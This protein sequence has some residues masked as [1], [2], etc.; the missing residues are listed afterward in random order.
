MDTLVLPAIQAIPVFCQSKTVT[1]QVGNSDDKLTQKL[2]HNFCE[3]MHTLVVD[4]TVEIHFSGSSNPTAPWQNA[5]W[6]AEIQNIDIEPFMQRVTS[7]RRRYNQASVAL[8]F[9][10]TKFI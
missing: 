10:E 1:V 7:L 3:E 8:T 9:G 6:V 4:Y 5:C 2:W